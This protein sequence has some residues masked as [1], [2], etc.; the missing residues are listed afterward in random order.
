MKLFIDSVDKLNIFSQIGAQA[1]EIEVSSE[2]SKEGHLESIFKVLSLSPNA[3]SLAIHD[4]YLYPEDQNTQYFC[5]RV[6]QEFP[7]ISIT[8][9]SARAIDGR[10]GR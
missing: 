6:K 3:L 8:W 2:I 7:H 9:L 4:D 1:E 10:H 5:R